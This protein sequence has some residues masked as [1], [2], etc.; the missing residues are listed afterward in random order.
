[1][2]NEMTKI[3]KAFYIMEAMKF[4]GVEPENYSILLKQAG[5]QDALLAFLEAELTGETK[6]F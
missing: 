3:Q 5:S 4:L 2:K 1:M 6:N